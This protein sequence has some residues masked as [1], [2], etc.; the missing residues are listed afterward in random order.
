MSDRYQGGGQVTKER[1]TVSR[2]LHQL[3]EGVRREVEVTPRVGLVIGH[4]DD[5][6]AGQTPVKRG[7][8]VQELVMPAAGEACAHRVPRPAQRCHRL[9]LERVEPLIVGAV[10]DKVA[11]E[12]RVV[13]R[14]HLGGVAAVRV[15]VE[16]DLAEWIA[17][18]TARRSSATAALP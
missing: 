9:R 12:P 2:V 1:V 16:V 17:L 18:R 7:D 6:M 10:E 5:R 14:E 3:G 15:A 13:D 11:H 4:A 8:V